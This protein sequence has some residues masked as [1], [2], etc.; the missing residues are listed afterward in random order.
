MRKRNAVKHSGLFAY[1]TTN[2]FKG[3]TFIQFHAWSPQWKVSDS[4]TKEDYKAGQFFLFGAGGLTVAALQQWQEMIGKIKIKRTFLFVLSAL[5]WFLQSF[6]VD[7]QWNIPWMKWF[8]YD[9]RVDECLNGTSNIWRPVRGLEQ[10]KV[11]SAIIDLRIW[12]FIWN[13]KGL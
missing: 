3:L 2:V 10:I 8:R 5:L 11:C 7:H 4:T 6:R 9:R 12:E 1:R 13:F